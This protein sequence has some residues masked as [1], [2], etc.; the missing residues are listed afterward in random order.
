MTDT[1]EHVQL[2]ESEL[3]T[4]RASVGYAVGFVD[5]SSGLPGDREVTVA[6]DLDGAGVFYHAPFFMDNVFIGDG[7]EVYINVRGYASTLRAMRDAV[8]E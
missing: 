1:G 8:K 2:A 6:Y 7:E 5:N 4:S 3:Q